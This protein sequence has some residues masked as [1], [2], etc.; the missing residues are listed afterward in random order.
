M[1]LVGLVC[2]Y[3]ERPNRRMNS[4]FSTPS[5][6]PFIRPLTSFLHFT[7]ISCS[8][9]RSL[10]LLLDPLRQIS[11]CRRPHRATLSFAPLLSCN[12]PNALD[13]PVPASLRKATSSLRSLRR[14]ASGVLMSSSL[15]PLHPFCYYSY[16]FA[17]KFLSLM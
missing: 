17:F 6:L 4:Y 5:P 12:P 7:P 11:L 14:S 9:E 15:F 13:L 1:T 16:C 2:V 3:E 10:T 8:P